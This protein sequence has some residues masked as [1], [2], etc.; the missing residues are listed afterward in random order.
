MSPSPTSISS[1]LQCAA[2]RMRACRVC[3]CVCVCARAR[4]CVF[5]GVVCVRVRVCGACAHVRHTNQQRVI[6]M[7]VIV[8]TR[9]GGR[10]CV[11]IVAH[12][13]LA[14][15]AE[16][17]VAVADEAIHRHNPLQLRATSMA[18]SA[19]VIQTDARCSLNARSLS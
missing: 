9:G 4:G 15:L 17:V 8:I 13:E 11:R 18:R 19:R 6:I 14:V 2:K 10:G 16:E 3:V 7:V 5:V 1:T 12:H